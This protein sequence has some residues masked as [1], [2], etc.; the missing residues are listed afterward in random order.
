[1]GEVGGAAAAEHEFLQALVAGLEFQVALEEVAQALPGVVEPPGGV[2]EGDD[3]VDAFVE[4]FLDELLL[5]REAPVDG[6]DADVGGAGD[7]V[8]ADVETDLGDQFAGGVVEVENPSPVVSK[9]GA[10]R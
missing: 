7:V 2:D 3:L 9:A 4:Q 5:V 1:L 8:V 10:A 6:P